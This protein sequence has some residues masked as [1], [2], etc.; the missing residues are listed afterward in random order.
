VRYTQREAHQP[1]EKPVEK[2]IKLLAYWPGVA[3]VTGA[4]FGD[5]K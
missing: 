1:G 2:H 3:V 5:R 4:K